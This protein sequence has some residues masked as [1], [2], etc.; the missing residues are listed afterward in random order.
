MIPQH[1]EAVDRGP[2][3]HVVFFIVQALVCM[4][5]P[6][7]SPSV[8]APEDTLVAALARGYVEDDTS[9]AAIQLS[10]YC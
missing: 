4:V 3:G 8:P 9:W 6:S 5:S 2:R 7:P 1:G 10:S